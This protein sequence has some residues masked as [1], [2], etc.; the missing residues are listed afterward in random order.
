MSLP[1]IGPLCL[2]FRVHIFVDT[3]HGWAVGS[4]PSHLIADYFQLL[5]SQRAL[6]HG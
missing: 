5:R 2:L 3:R 6:M 4:F 1:A